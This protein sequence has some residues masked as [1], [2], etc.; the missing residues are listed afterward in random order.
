MQPQAAG[1]T[2]TS[3]AQR[4]RRARGVWRGWHRLWRKQPAERARHEREDRMAVEKKGETSA[5]AWPS[6]FR[7]TIGGPARG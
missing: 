3:T 5:A 2:T 6:I 7:A 1:A 4:R